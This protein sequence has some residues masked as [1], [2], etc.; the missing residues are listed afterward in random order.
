MNKK[1]QTYYALYIRAAALN[2]VF[3]RHYRVLKELEMMDEL[4]SEIKAMPQYDDI[5]KLLE[6]VNK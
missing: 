3:I 6:S 4:E 5:E 1:Q 2:D